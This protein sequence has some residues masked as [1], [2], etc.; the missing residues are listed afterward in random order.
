MTLSAQLNFRFAVVLYSPNFPRDS[1]VE[2][3]AGPQGLYLQTPDVGKVS[4]FVLTNPEMGK[5]QYLKALN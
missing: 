2:L 4:G 1:Q 3:C 5:F